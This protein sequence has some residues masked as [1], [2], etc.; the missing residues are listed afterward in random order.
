MHVDTYGIELTAYEEE[1]IESYFQPFQNECR[2]FGRLKEFSMEHLG[3]RCHGYIILNE[4]QL[5]FMRSKYNFDR[6]DY[7]PEYDEHQPVR[8]IVKDIVYMGQ[9]LPEQE[10][11][12]LHVTPKTVP[13]MLED[14]KFMHQL[15]ITIKDIDFN[16]YIH[17]KFLD[18]S[19][20]WTAPHPLLIKGKDPEKFPPLRRAIN[21]A[22]SMDDFIDAW[23]EHNPRQKIWKRF[24]PHRSYRYRLRPRGKYKYH[25]GYRP[26]EFTYESAARRFKIDPLKF[27]GE[28]APLVEEFKA[29]LPKVSTEVALVLRPP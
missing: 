5:D 18:L 6:W 19:H 14:L 1:H 22:F 12:A 21:D 10:Y 23:N 11:I 15:G 29:V 8:A 13:K 25:W 24:L 7:D 3:V 17:N 27:K 16:N 20:A 4:T 9:D 28:D 26:E 2:A